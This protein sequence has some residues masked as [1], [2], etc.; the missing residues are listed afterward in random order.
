MG[1]TL[2]PD[3]KPCLMAASREALEACA[4]ANTRGVIRWFADLPVSL[5]YYLMGVFAFIVISA[6]V[7]GLLFP[8]LG[9]GFRLF[10]AVLSLLVFSLLWVGM[11]AMHRYFQGI[12]PY[13]EGLINRIVVQTLCSVAFLVSARIILILL[14]RDYIPFELNRPMLASI[15]TVDILVALLF[16]AAYVGEHFFKK[17]REELFK[18]EQY[19]REFAQ[20]Q[21]DNLKNQLNPHF[22]FNSLASL[23]GLIQEDPVLAARFLTHLSKVYRYLLQHEDGS[24]V[25]LQTEM[26]FL[27]HYLQL[28]AVRMGE[29]LHLEIERQTLDPNA[30]IVPASLFALVENA[31]KHNSTHKES[32]LLVRIE[33]KSGFLW[34][35][36]TLQVK[37]TPETSNG[38]GLEKLRTLYRFHSPE[39]VNI[40]NDGTHFRVGIPLIDPVI[41]PRVATI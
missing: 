22:L 36:N 24:L 31:I 37:R 27:D 18:T 23:Q 21:F 9:V 13:D 5:R 2:G 29:G 26:S 28:L 1:K 16:N 10:T 14:A 15:V 32:P 33:Q 35:M 6:V 38:Q 34:V 17:W 11:N 30:L 4:P 40:L 12:M 7:R 20:T 8:E 39:P 3:G 19:Q 41:N 25:N